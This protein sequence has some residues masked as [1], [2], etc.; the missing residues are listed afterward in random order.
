MLFSNASRIPLVGFLVTS[1][2]ICLIIAKS[3][4][5]EVVVGSVRKVID[6]LEAYALEK[7]QHTGL[8]I[9]DL[10]N[11]LEEAQS[12]D[13]SVYLKKKES[14]PSFSLLVDF[15]LIPMLR[16]TDPTRDG[17]SQEPGNTARKD[18]IVRLEKYWKIFRPFYLGHMVGLSCHRSPKTD[19]LLLSLNE[20]KGYQPLTKKMLEEAAAEHKSLSQRCSEIRAYEDV[21][22]SATE[23]KLIFNYRNRLE[24]KLLDEKIFP[25]IPLLKTQ[26]DVNGVRALYISELRKKKIVVINGGLF[27]LP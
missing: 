23:L 14:E 3:A 7:V 17:V 8:S 22:S 6:K 12:W 21:F 19:K 18:Y 13:Q 15:L 4:Q 11:A 26:D 1:G 27:R 24:V 20:G 5:A 25:S 16:Y 9:P 10:K 2:L